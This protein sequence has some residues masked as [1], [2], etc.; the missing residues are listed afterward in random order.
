[1]CGLPYQT[2]A[3]EFPRPRTCMHGVPQPARQSRARSSV[4]KVALSNRGRHTQT[5]NLYMLVDRLPLA[6]AYIHQAIERKAAARG[7]HDLWGL[8]RVQIKD[9]GG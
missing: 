6:L 2:D 4:D 8:S 3:C 1:M 7:K 5:F 9:K